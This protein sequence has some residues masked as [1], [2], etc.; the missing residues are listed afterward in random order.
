[1]AL[2]KGFTL[3]TDIDLGHLLI[4]GYETHRVKFG[5]QLETRLPDLKIAAIVNDAVATFVTANYNAQSMCGK[6]VPMVSRPP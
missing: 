5:D 1:M 4:Q 6:P 2:S 3:A